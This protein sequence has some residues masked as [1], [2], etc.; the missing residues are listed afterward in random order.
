MVVIDGCYP[1]PITVVLGR[2]SYSLDRSRR[3]TNRITGE[4]WSGMI[5]STSYLGIN[6]ITHTLLYSDNYWIEI[7]VLK[8]LTKGYIFKKPIPSVIY[9]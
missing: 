4:Q 2:E 8:N 7:R 5:I 3:T 9:F 6:S 1:R